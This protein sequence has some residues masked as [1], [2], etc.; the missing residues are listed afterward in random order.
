MEATVLTSAG[1]YAMIALLNLPLCY[2]Y[3]SSICVNLST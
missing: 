3:M 2:I 1:I